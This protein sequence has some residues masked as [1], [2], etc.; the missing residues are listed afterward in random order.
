MPSPYRSL[1]VTR[2]RQDLLE[3]DFLSRPGATET[4]GVW[5]EFFVARWDSDGRRPAEFARA[6][7][8]DACVDAAAKS[9][10][11]FVR[12][13][14]PRCAASGVSLGVGLGHKLW[15][16][17]PLCRTPAECHV[18]FE[19]AWVRLR[20]AFA[21][22][23][24]DVLAVGADPWRSVDDCGPP[25]EA[26]DVE[27]ERRF[28]SASALGLAALRLT[29]RSGVVL[30]WGNAV[31]A[32]LRWKAA[33]LVAP[34]ANSLFAHSPVVG[35]AHP[36]TKSF[37][38]RAWRLAA[39]DLCSPPPTF[40]DAPDGDRVAQYLT[41]ALEARSGALDGALTFGRWLE[42]G[43][44]GR[45]PEH[46][47][48]RRHLA[49]LEPQV[50]PTGALE[51]AC[52]DAQPRVFAL[53]PLAFSIALLDDGSSLPRVTERFGLR[54]REL[55]RRYEL[56]EGDGLG[57]PSFAADGRALIAVAADAVLRASPSWYGPALR[58]AFVHF[59]ERCALR[60]RSP[61]DELLDVFL[62][63][64]DVD[65]A[66]LYEHERRLLQRVA[67]ARAG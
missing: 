47:D 35:S 8:V 15:L 67:F 36:G 12:A 2:L 6:E 22:R 16:A 17:S 59:A 51:L 34:F 5:S 25:D 26:E 13:A 24:L 10:A 63:R 45:F 19:H 31:Q 60:G 39:P 44:A 33:Q 62:S 7:L 3:D 64:G 49:T 61:A 66:A 42:H 50:R 23:H 56:A 37:A 52:F 21:A 30:G 4:Y 58:V 54:A 65:R 38:A 27:R 32:P 43:H 40:A 20:G 9:G 1:D 29:A 55:H 48:W 18:A 53:A 11:E 46:A 28:A 41:F 14:R 57:E